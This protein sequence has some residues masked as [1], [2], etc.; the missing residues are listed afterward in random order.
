MRSS[1]QVT[2]LR[3]AVS[4]SCYACA[5]TAP[6]DVTWG[7]LTVALVGPVRWLANEAGCLVGAGTRE[8]CGRAY[9]NYQQCAYAA[10]D[11]CDIPDQFNCY[12]DPALFQS[13][14]ACATYLTQYRRS[15]QFTGRAFDQCVDATDTS[16]SASAALVVRVMCGPPG[17]GG[18]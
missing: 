9:S 8:A 13:G 5:Y 14:G 7:A 6:D 10:C 1:V 17:D 15:C 4:A 18:A 16:F 2:D 12:D 11:G 3:R